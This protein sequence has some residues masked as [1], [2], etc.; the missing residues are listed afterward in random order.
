MF[1]AK[2]WWFVPC[3]ASLNQIQQIDDACLS[4]SAR[5]L[6]FAHAHAT[7]RLENKRDHTEE[8]REETRGVSFTFQRRG[9]KKKKKV[10]DGKYERAQVANRGFK[11]CKCA[12]TRCEVAEHYPNLHEGS[13][14]FRPF[15]RHAKCYDGAPGPSD[16]IASINLTFAMQ[17]AEVHGHGLLER[18]THTSCPPLHLCPL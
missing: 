8:K 12:S 10:E 15:P 1:C 4:C 13:F 6:A 5:S 16:P 18:G 2:N 14:S 17:P 7:E 9:I 11:S 3:M